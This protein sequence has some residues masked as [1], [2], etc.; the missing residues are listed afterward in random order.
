MR[1]SLGTESECIWTINPT[2]LSIYVILFDIREKLLTLRIWNVDI[3]K[4]G[5]FMKFKYS[6]PL[7]AD[8]E[9][10]ISFPSLTATRNKQKFCCC[11]SSSPNNSL[12]KKTVFDEKHSRTKRRSL[13]ILHYTYISIVNNLQQQRQRIIWRHRCAYIWIMLV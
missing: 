6:V 10:S 11:F 12:K 9:T 2:K 1:I 7:V 3:Y 5:H 4:C 13:L 8:E